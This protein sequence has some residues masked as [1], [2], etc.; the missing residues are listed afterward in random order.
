MLLYLRILLFLI[1]PLLSFYII[2][3]FMF[4]LYLREHKSDIFLT[5]YIISATVKYVFSLWAVHICCV[6]VFLWIIVTSSKIVKDLVGIQSAFPTGI[7]WSFVL[8]YVFKVKI[9][10]DTSVLNFHWNLPDLNTFSSGQP[11]QVP[12]LMEAW[13]SALPQR[14]AAFQLI[15]FPQALLICLFF[16]AHFYLQWLPS[17]RYICAL[18]IHALLTGSYT[19]LKCNGILLPSPSLPVEERKYR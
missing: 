11:C 7:V 16:S 6:S 12:I 10:R 14:L 19:R 13:E 15:S 3:H 8:L 9:T 17:H 1:S 4:L 2:F 5:W 18:L